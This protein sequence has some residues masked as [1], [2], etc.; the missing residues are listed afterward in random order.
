MKDEKLR[1]DHELPAT[2]EVGRKHAHTE[3]RLS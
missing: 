1:P 3:R 2:A